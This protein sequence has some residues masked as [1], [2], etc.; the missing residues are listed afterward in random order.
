MPSLGSLIVEMAA[1]TA[2]FETDTG[3][4]ARVAKKRASEIDAAFSRMGSRLS[5]IFAGLAGAFSLSAIVRATAE[6]EKAFG[7]LEHAVKNNAGAAQLT[8]PQLAAMASQLQ[9]LTTF[10]DEAIME[11]QAL[12]LSFHQI[13]GQEF[14][15]A[16][17]AVLDLA[18]AMG[19][20]LQTSAKMVGRALADPVKGMTALSR[21][22]VVLDKDQAALIKRLAE[23]GHLAQ[24]QGLLL[25]EL[26]K[27]FGGAAAA[28]RNTFAGALEGVKNAFND[29]L[30]A[31][32]GVPGATAALNEFTKQLQDPQTIAGINGITGAMIAGLSATIPLLSKVAE[33]W[34]NIGS[35]IMAAAPTWKEFASDLSNRDLTQ[36]IATVQ[37]EFDNT[38]AAAQA[39][40]DK[41]SQAYAD[42]VERANQYAQRLAELRGK[43]DQGLQV[44]AGG[45]LQI[46]APA[47]AGAPGAAAVAAA[48]PPE[49]FEKAA[50]KLREQIA[51][52]GKTGEAAKLAYQLANGALENVSDAEG[53]QLLALARQY[54]AIVQS[55][56][57]SKAAQ[58][59]RQ[60]SIEELDKMT[61]AAE[62][63]AATFGKDAV[64]VL[65]YRLAHGDLAK[66]LEDAG[67]SAE[68]YAERLRTLTAQLEQ[69]HA[70][71]KQAVHD[72]AALQKTMDEGKAVIEATRTP[73]EKY[74][75][76]IERL[77]K[78]REA[79]ALGDNSDQVY[80]RAVDAAQKAFDEASKNSDKF[81]EQFKDGVFRSLG[82]GIYSAMT[83]AAKKGWKGFLDAGI[84]TINR[85]VAQALAKRLAEG[86]FGGGGGDPNAQGGGGGGWLSKVG[87][88]FGSLFGGGRAYGGEVSA[89]RMYRIQERGAEF[90]RPNV[91]GHIIPLSKMPAAGGGKVYQTIQVAGR[92]DA[93]T[94]QQ[95]ALETAR[96]QRIQTARL[97]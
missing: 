95:I 8:T 25:D 7:A 62:Q 71:A 78:L 29:L 27:K 30:E 5:G 68:A 4:A 61:A 83:D 76:E 12:L 51:L 41:G 31:K 24:A 42:L 63:E 33:G 87:S 17:T 36:Q 69:M 77:N 48:P 56:E 90:F 23:T 96:Q 79:G 94:A 85:L 11:M 39:M 75:D 15:R 70:A 26:E 54:D 22:G 58:K 89:G 93:R 72:A 38:A 10:S 16:Q 84:E 97:G 45:Q 86:L 74:N 60:R 9:G 32:G 53:K 2:K 66:T 55:T 21:A 43:L 18:T 3:R 47:A 34:G 92:V 64:A 52:Y 81:S 88:L 91:G 67:P 80:R 46:S 14:K 19:Q 44:K 1:N 20:D 57:A 35:A 73:L 82:D 6:A 65:E 37:R 50:E 40:G 59:T 13:G 49:A 28:A